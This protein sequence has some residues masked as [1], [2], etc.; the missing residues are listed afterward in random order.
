MLA[1]DFS[2][3]PAELTLFHTDSLEHAT[4]AIPIVTP[5]GDLILAGGNPEN[6]YNPLSTVWLYHYGSASEEQA[7]EQTA[8]LQ[9]I[10]LCLWIFLTVIVLL[11]LAH[12][13]YLYRKRKHTVASPLI[14]NDQKPTDEE[15]MQRICQSIER[16]RQY[17][18]SRLR[19][20]DIAVEL[21]VSVTTLT[22]C[23]QSQRHCTFAQLIAEYRVHYAQKLLSENPEM[24]LN[25]VITESGFTSESTFFRSFKAVTGL[26][27]KEWLAQSAKLE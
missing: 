26:S 11:I 5:D 21:G 1:I 2:Q 15:L 17:L 16:D 20:S 25:A 23:I 9:R 6:N 12:I 14:S 3:Q 8:N 13:I 4:V 27:P 19:L 18:T 24:K 22:D 10:P 7:A